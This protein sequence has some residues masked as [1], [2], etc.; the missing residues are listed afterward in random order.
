MYLPAFILPSSMWYVWQSHKDSVSPS[1]TA[2]SAQTLVFLSIL[3]HS[4]Q[5]LPVKKNI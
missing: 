2:N 1:L 3:S 4:L 5:E